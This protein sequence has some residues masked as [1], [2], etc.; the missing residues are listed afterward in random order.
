MEHR[1]GRA[2]G[3]ARRARVMVAELE[4]RLTELGDHRPLPRPRA[5]YYAA[6]R[7][8]GRLVIKRSHSVDTFD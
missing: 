2:V 7:A 5:L 1:Y 3:E 8:V 4:A 6:G